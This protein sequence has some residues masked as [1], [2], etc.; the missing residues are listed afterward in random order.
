M[1]CCQE[2][3]S[4]SLEL[5]QTDKIQEM[6]DSFASNV[7]DQ[8]SGLFFPIRQ[9]VF[10]HSSHGMIEETYKLEDIIGSGSLSSVRKATHLET[11]IERAVKIIAKN[12]LTDDQ[13]ENLVTEVEALKNFD[14]PNIVRIIEVIEDSFKLNIVTE[15]CVGGELFDKIFNNRPFT[16]NTAAKY[17]FQLLS[18]LI[19]IH[20][21]GFIHGDL[22]PENI[23]MLTEENDSIIKIIDFGIS[24]QCIGKCK[25]TRFIGTVTP[26]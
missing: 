4:K 18:G 8:I 20:K 17:M 13:A 2:R 6:F 12:V 9:K 1:G 25:L 5:V 14:H 16:E 10:V 23:L 3:M 19:H 21:K 24:K 26:K 7:Q 22:K 11:S 15:L